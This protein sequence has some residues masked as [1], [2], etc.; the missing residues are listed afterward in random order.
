MKEVRDNIYDVLLGL[1]PEVARKFRQNYVPVR[2]YARPEE[3][4]RGV[5]GYFF[6]AFSLMPVETTR[7]LNC[8][9]GNSASLNLWMEDFQNVVAPSFVKNAH[10]VFA[11]CQSLEENLTEFGTLLGAY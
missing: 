6:N 8:I 9:V 11:P 7:E 2:A 5:A 4:F 1:S 10:F 3:E